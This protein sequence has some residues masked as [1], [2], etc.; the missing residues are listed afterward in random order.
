MERR[1]DKTTVNSKK[2]LIRSL[3]TFS[4]KCEY[5]AVLDE[6]YKTLDSIK[7]K[8]E[9]YMTTKYEDLLLYETDTDINF[10]LMNRISND[11]INTSTINKEFI[12]TPFLEF[13]KKY[14]NSYVKI[15][16]KEDSS[17]EL[18]VPHIER[19]RNKSNLDVVDEEGEDLSYY[20]K[21]FELDKGYNLYFFDEY[22]FDNKYNVIFIKRQSDK[23][24]TNYK[25]LLTY[26]D[27]ILN[28]RKDEKIKN[29]LKD[30][31]NKYKEKF[32]FINEKIV[33]NEFALNANIKFMYAKKLITQLKNRVYFSDTTFYT[34]KFKSK[35]D[36]EKEYVPIKFNFMNLYLYDLYQLMKNRQ[37]M[38][39]YFMKE[40]KIHDFKKTMEKKDFLFYDNYFNLEEYSVILN[41]LIN[42]QRF[43]NF[44]F[45]MLT[46]F[47]TTKEYDKILIIDDFKE[48]FGSYHLNIQL[49]YLEI[50]MTIISNDENT[51]K[52]MKEINDINFLELSIK[53]TLLT[54][55]RLFYNRRDKN[56]TIYHFEQYLS[57]DFNFIY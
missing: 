40:R 46:E 5:I 11:E 55:L 48:I 1:Y 57:N 3:N 32:F 14:E 54:Y 12:T 29:S 41:K 22:P 13:K 6:D 53:E 28:I 31:V 26:I 30:V 42:Q 10:K 18:N 51:I 34:T 56:N 33:I 25:L 47:Y 20:T 43:A 17:F 8:D 24:L 23:Y 27:N 39:S 45:L 44:F 16:K 2:H 4:K 7:H 38:R 15:E 21:Y 19:Y 49:E 9:D 52:Y 37:Y 50:L 36:K 35:K